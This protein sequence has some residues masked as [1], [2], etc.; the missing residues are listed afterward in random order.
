M[1]FLLSKKKNLIFIFVKYLHKHS[2]KTT[3]DWLM[4][5][6]VF[7]IFI[8]GQLIVPSTQLSL[9]QLVS[10]TLTACPPRSNL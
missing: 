8:K 10:L 5:Q 2:S 4:L 3:N 6:T 7:D 9:K 1:N